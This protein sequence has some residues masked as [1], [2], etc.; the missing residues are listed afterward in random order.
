MLKKKNRRHHKW[1]VL[2]FPFFFFF[3]IRLLH[4]NV[5]PDLITQTHNFSVLRKRKTY[6]TKS[7]HLEL[8]KEN[9]FHV[10]FLFAVFS[11]FSYFFL[12][13]LCAQIY[14]LNISFVV[15]LAKYRNWYL[16]FFAVLV[17]VYFRFLVT[18]TI[19]LW[20]C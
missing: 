20:A 12:P 17:R 9:F 10:Y 16:T 6:N 4:F 19:K 13:V 18:L 8:N 15:F 3:S 5:F 7:K 2:W 14:L 11:F 1:W